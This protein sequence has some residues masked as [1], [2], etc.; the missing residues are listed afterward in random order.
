MES[1]LARRQSMQAAMRTLPAYLSA[2][3]AVG[4]TRVAIMGDC[5]PK[6]RV[7]GVERFS[8]LAAIAK[9]GRSRFLFKSAFSYSSWSLSVA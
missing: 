2:S 9:A 1:A 6:Q 3:G 4:V 8:E 5:A 7:V